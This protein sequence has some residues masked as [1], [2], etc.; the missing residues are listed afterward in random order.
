MV[1]ETLLGAFVD[2]DR[3]AGALR[4]AKTESTDIMRL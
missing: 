2:L 4:C 3:V 1:K